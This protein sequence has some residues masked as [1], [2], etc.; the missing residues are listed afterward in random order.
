MD[1]IRSRQLLLLS[2]RA[3]LLL[4]WTGGTWADDGTGILSAAPSLGSELITNGNMETGTPPSSWSAVASAVLTA[5]TERTGGAGTKSLNV[6]RGTTD[7][8]ASQNYSLADG[9]W[10][11]L[12]YWYRCL[13]ATSATITT[14]SGSQSGY[15]GVATSWTNKTLSG[16]K[17]G[18]GSGQYR[19]NVVGS[20]GNQAEFDDVSAKLIVPASLFATFSSS[21][22]AARMGVR[23]AVL[24][25]G[26]FAGV[27]SKLDSA[28]NP[29]N[30][31]IAT[32][33]G[34]NTRFVKCVAGVYT[35]L[36]V[37]PTAFVSDATIEIV[38]PTNESCELWYNGSKVGTTQA[39]ADATIISNTR[40]GLI[41]TSDL[42]KLRQPMYNG[43]NVP[44][45]LA[46]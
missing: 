2:G 24:E 45:F 23:L 36:E 5:S 19:I 21:L 15:T 39:V 25:T 31:V 46:A 14:N 33:D 30:F 16:R 28:A 3:T 4:P 42:N 13:T 32:H 8:S 37:T 41:S 18:V 17:V 35:S 29:Q 20:Q 26:E 12:N 34:I 9:E 11:K 43:V 6:E 1:H 10:F 44:F 7:Y 40:H 27:A 22:P 38:W